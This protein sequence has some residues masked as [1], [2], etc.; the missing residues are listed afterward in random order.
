[1]PKVK[2]TVV[3]PAGV[4]RLEQEL[5]DLQ[6]VRRRLLT[7]RLEHALAVDADIA[8]NADYLD[9]KEDLA[10]LEQR[11]ARLRQAL[12][13]ARVIE[14]RGDRK[15]VQLGSTVRL[16]DFDTGERLDLQLV[17][18][19]EAD[20]AANRISHESPVGAAVL[21]RRKGE[22][23]RVRAPSRIVRFEIVDVLTIAAEE[24]AA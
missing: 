8:D 16:R 5:D 2:E 1:V 20:A 19:L 3:T 18:P 13:A 12:A 9:V 11:V 4:V 6:S 24:K 15:Q 23:V 7:E 22:C 17:G 21:G 14:T 10:V